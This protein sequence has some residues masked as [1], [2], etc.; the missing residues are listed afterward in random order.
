MREVNRDGSWEE[1]RQVDGK[2]MVI[3]YTKDKQQHRDK[4]IAR[5]EGYFGCLGVWYQWD[6][7]EIEK[8]NEFVVKNFLRY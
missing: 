1:E 4:M 2:M 8:L 5:I 7:P 6:T 3:H